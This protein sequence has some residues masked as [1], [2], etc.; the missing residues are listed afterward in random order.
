MSSFKESMFV[1]RTADVPRWNIL[2][3]FY[4][5]NYLDADQG[6]IHIPKIIHQIWLGSPL[7]SKY[8]ELQNT[9]K[10][11]HPDWEYRLWTDAESEK[12]T[13]VHR[14]MYDNAVNVGVKSDILRYEI[15]YQFGGLYVDT[16]FE[17]LKSFEE[18]HRKCDFYAGLL[19]S[20]NELRILTGIIGS[21][22]KGDVIKNIL[23]SIADVRKVSST[24]SVLKATGPAFFT[25]RFFSTITEQKSIIFP[26][27]FFYPSPN[28][29]VGIPH[30]VQKKHIREE[31]F[32]IHYWDMSW[33]KGKK[34][35][36]VIAGK[37]IKH[38]L[39]YGIVKY[40][41]Y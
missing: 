26:A 3:Y 27:T 20:T 5:R 19:Q 10:K 6:D 7:P 41:Y 16:D 29:N 23:D 30:D 12:L 32:A 8:V 22:P 38:L 34:S 37:I 31:S 33:T 9:W 4:E 21:I 13:M 39:P 24:E 25:D 35:L 40:F 2:Q 14:D 18:M 15:L 28:S 11:F 36:K 17:C 1:P